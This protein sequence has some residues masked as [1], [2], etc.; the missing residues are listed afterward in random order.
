MA[1]WGRQLRTLN[2]IHGRLLAVAVLAADLVDGDAVVELGL[3]LVA[4]M[5]EAV[6]LR[7][8]LGVEL[9]DIVVDDARGLVDDL[10]V[11][12]FSL[13]EARLFAL[14]VQR[15]VQRDSFFFWYAAI[16]GVEVSVVSPMDDEGGKSASEPFRRERHVPDAFLD[17]ILGSRHD[18][19]VGQPVQRSLLVLVAVQSP[20]RV[21]RVAFSQGQVVE[22]GDAI[23][24]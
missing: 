4:K 18:S 24:I 12:Q 22:A 5:A 20:G 15:P 16:H 13:E 9:P 11:E 3:L 23:L 7:R 1:D 14:S 2:A 17:L 21:V 19:F 10:L 6:P 8:D